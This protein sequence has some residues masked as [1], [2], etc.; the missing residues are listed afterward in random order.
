MTWQVENKTLLH[1]ILAGETALLR[2]CFALCSFGWTIWLFTDKLFS[3]NH[4]ATVLLA[5]P[6]VLGT[7]FFIHACALL[8]GVRTHKY[9]KGLLFL[10]GI[11]GV[12]LW[13]GTGISETLN[14]GTIG[15]SVFAGLIAIFL[16]IRYP[17]HYTRNDK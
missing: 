7:L 9:S 2:L 17:T 6:Y 15:P 10:E 13:V 8:Y 1:L 3:V 16:L 12:F 14:Q 11:L 4:P 5:G